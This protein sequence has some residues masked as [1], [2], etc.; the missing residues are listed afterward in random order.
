MYSKYNQAVF[1]T[2]EHM[3]SWVL[4]TA[5]VVTEPKASHY[6]SKQQ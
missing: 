3:W 1:T 4:P 2:G 5:V 6:G